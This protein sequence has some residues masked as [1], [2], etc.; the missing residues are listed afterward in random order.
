M[1][2]ITVAAVLRICHLID[3][4]CIYPECITR[5]VTLQ[6]RTGMDEDIMG[7]R[8][9]DGKLCFDNIKAFR[10]ASCISSRR[11]PPAR[12]GASR[13][14]TPFLSPCSIES[15]V[16]WVGPVGMVSPSATY[17][18]KAVTGDSQ[19]D[20]INPISCSIQFFIP[21]KGGKGKPR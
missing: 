5:G 16:V 21:A 6:L 10:Y 3:E 13:G 7:E 19:E 14:K 17:I 18:V 15:L 9:G 4:G 20:T 11:E 2:R 12:G 8:A 1:I